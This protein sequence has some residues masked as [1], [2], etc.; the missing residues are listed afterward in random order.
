M[1]SPPFLIWNNLKKFRLK[2]PEPVDFG[3]VRTPFVG[4]RLLDIL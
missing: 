3:H 2:A 1:Y 4:N